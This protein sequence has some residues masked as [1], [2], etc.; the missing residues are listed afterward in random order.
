MLK[1]STIALAVVL[2]ALTAC[3]KEKTKE[4]KSYTLVGRI[5]S[6]E[7]QS[8][9]L[10]V[11]HEAIKGLMEGMTMPF[12]VKDAKLEDLPPDGTAITATLHVAEDEYWLT[13]VK[14]R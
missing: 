9:S 2:L 11:Q 10:V 8:N 1:R 6:R 7:V 4:S 3:H 13:D 12:P 14:R 5:V